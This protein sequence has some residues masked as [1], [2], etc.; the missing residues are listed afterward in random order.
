MPAC[1]GRM[2]ALLTGIRIK[3]RQM[4][5]LVHIRVANVWIHSP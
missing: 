4:L 2:Y 5:I 1:R 3:K